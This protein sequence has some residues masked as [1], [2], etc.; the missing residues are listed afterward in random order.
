MGDVVHV[1]VDFECS[2]QWVSCDGTQSGV[3][4]Y[5]IVLCLDGQ[6]WL[7]G[8]TRSAAL[9]RTSTSDCERYSGAQVWFA[10]TMHY[11]R[12]FAEAEKVDVGLLYPSVGV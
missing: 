11:C 10:G 3:F 6:Y 12:A 9:S 2:A 8:G 1:A 4:L 5:R 7:C